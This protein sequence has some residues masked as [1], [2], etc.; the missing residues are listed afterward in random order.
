MQTSLVNEKKSAKEIMIGIGVI[1]ILMLAGLAF[2]STG[3]AKEDYKPLTPQAQTAYDS[4]LQ[5]LCE[6]EKTLAAAKIMDVAN[7]VK[8]DVDMNSLL[9]K[10]DKNCRF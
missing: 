9:V 8:M 7:G 5:T 2:I 1:A 6:A 4:A 10:R 3:N